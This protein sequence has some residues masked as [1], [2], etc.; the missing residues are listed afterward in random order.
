MSERELEAI[1]ILKDNYNIQGIQDFKI[2]DYNIYLKR[3]S[4]KLKKWY[5]NLS[6]N[7]YSSYEL[8][9]NVNYLHNGR[10]CSRISV[11]KGISLMGRVKKDEENGKLDLLIYFIKFLEKLTT[12][13]LC[14]KLFMPFYSFESNDEIFIYVI[15]INNPGIKDSDSEIIKTYMNQF[16]N[17]YKF[18]SKQYI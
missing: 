2:I 18:N 10:I 5:L 8:S 1:K 9:T 14:L 11:T 17:K 7:D 3:M 15:V 12:K 16:K 13:N 4:E 6:I